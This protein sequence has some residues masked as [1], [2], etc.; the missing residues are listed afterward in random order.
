MKKARIFLAGLVCLALASCGTMG[1]GSGGVLGNIFGPAASGQSLGNILISVIGLDKPSQAELI[2][3][4]RYTQPGVAFTSENLLAKAGGEVAAAKI[5]EE[6]N[7]Y[8]KQFGV[9]S[10]NTVIQFNQDN[11]FTAKILGKT[12]SGNYTYDQQTC[13]ITLKT[14]LFTMPA[15]TKRTVNGMSILFESKKLLTV[16][17]TVAAISGNATLQTIGDLSTNYNGVRLGFDMKK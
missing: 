17:Q 4:W 9:S 15:Y 3:T 12:I 14:L 10:S 5:R 13:Q 11:T 7:T 6:L 8:Y 2:G 16:L 1:D